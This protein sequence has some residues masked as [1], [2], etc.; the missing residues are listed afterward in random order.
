VAAPNVAW[1]GTHPDPGT[2]AAPYR[3]YNIGNNN[4][5]E[6]LYLIQTLEQTLGRTAVK[7][8]LPMQMG[9]VPATYADVEALTQDTGFRPATPIEVGVERFVAWYRDYYKL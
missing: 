8:M 3:L 7:N 4:P 2:S 5:V 9:D 1:D 6:L